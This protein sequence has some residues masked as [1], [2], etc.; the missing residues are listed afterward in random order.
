MRDPLP[1][2]NLEQ[3]AAEFRTL[4]RRLDAHADAIQ[5]DAAAFRAL[6]GDPTRTGPAPKSDPYAAAGLE[7]VGEIVGIVRNRET[8]PD[9][10]LDRIGVDDVQHIYDAFIGPTVDAVEDYLLAGDRTRA[11]S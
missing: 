2:P 7:V 9:A 3:V 4:A 1:D 10:T 11:V 6:G 8:V 5:A